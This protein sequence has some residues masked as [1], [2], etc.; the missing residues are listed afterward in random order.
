MRFDAKK[1]QLRSI[2]K[3]E[4]FPFINTKKGALFGLPNHGNIGDA[5]IVLGEYSFFKNCG[6]KLIYERQ[7]LDS[8]PLPELSKDCII[9]LQ[10]GGDF[11]DIWRDVQESRLQVI[12]KY[13]N[14]R[15]IV[16]PETVSYCS[17]RLLIEDSRT[18]SQCK[19]LIICARDRFSYELL[20]K[21]FQNTVLLV[22][23][24]AFY[25]DEKH[26]SG[27]KCNTTKGK[28]FLL[29]RDREY[30]PTETQEQF[31]DNAFVSDWPT[32]MSKPL[33]LKV[34]RK[35]TDLSN[36]RYSIGHVTESLLINYLSGCLLKI[37]YRKLTHAGIE[38]IMSFD[39]LYL[40]RMH[41]AIASVLAEKSFVLLNNSYGKNKNFYNTWFCDL[42]G[43]CL[44]D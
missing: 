44:Y 20:K 28:L 12:E 15:I 21:Y 18:F 5:M 10:G 30:L 1:S 40:T 14:H 43:A 26:Y 7:L 2:I 39:E 22:P 31:I 41:A 13:K 27:K 23:D 17:E 4:L 8:T 32:L 34:T 11:G 38:F 19:D 42:E 29:R 25:M 6:I 33:Y 37:A 3:R 36:H 35:L 9:F 24:M 16:F